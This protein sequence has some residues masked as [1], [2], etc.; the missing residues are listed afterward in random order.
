MKFKVQKNKNDPMATLAGC[1][2]FEGISA[3]E[4]GLFSKAFSLT[5]NAKHPNDEARKWVKDVVYVFANQTHLQESQVVKLMLSNGSRIDAHHMITKAALKVKKDA[6][7]KQTFDSQ[8]NLVWDGYSSRDRELL[9]VQAMDG[10]SLADFMRQKW[11]FAI[12]IR[13]DTEKNNFK[14]STN[15]HQRKEESDNNKLSRA[16]DAVKEKRPDLFVEAR[17]IAPFVNGVLERLTAE[18]KGHIGELVN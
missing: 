9:S 18:A 10:N 4:R 1:F 13:T 7:L 3:R 11:G 6:A 12:S 17:K 2:L 5:S 15:S 14:G 16:I 8:G